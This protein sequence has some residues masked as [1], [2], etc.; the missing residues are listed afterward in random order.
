M[1]DKQFRLLQRIN[2]FFTFVSPMK[3][4]VKNLFTLFLER[5]Y[6]M[7]DTGVYFTNPVLVIGIF[8]IYITFYIHNRINKMSVF[9][10]KAFYVHTGIFIVKYCVPVH[11]SLS[12][13]SW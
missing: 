1:R 11:F 13:K 7:S 10:T 8:F 9:L 3:A 2:C 5:E 6:E 4:K 12:Q